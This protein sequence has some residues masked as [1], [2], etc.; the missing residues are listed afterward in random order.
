MGGGTIENSNSYVGGTQSRISST[1]PTGICPVYFKKNWTIRILQERRSMKV[2]DYI[3]NDVGAIKPGKVF[4]Y[5]DILREPHDREAVI[6]ALNRMV[7]NGK[8]TK[9][10]KGRYYRPENSVFG[11]L[12]PSQAEVVKDL[13]WD[14]RQRIGYLSGLS[15]YP[16][17]GL[18]TQRSNTIQIASNDIRPAFK[19]GKYRITYIRQKNPITAEIIPLLQI[20]DAI[21]YIK[22]IP[23]SSIPAA[24]YRLKA[25]V[26][27]LS[28]KE[29]EKMVQLVGKYPPSTRAL[30]GS[31]LEAAG[32]W[33]FRNELKKNLNP[34]TQY[35]YPEAH[36]ALPTANDW[37]IV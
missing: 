23:D 27:E 21:R 33:D 18:T 36:T 5:K 10:S 30:L 3:Q 12:P 9:L 31:I 26:K 24:C 17:L 35:K 14:G 16:D 20:L 22:K 32:N 6:K 7:K 4:T 8:L 25:I 13:L 15:I 34:I 11:V 1:P 2:A 37:N 19:R 28:E 29:Q